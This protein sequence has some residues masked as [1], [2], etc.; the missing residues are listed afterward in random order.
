[1]KSSSITRKIILACLLCAFGILIGLIG[2]V[3]G[4]DLETKLDSIGI[5]KNILY[6]Y[7]LIFSILSIFCVILYER[8]NSELKPEHGSTP[9]FITRIISSLF[10]NPVTTYVWGFLTSNKTFSEL[11]LKLCLVFCVVTT[12]LTIIIATPVIIYRRIAINSYVSNA[13]NCLKRQDYRCFVS[14]H[15]MVITNYPEFNEDYE[16]LGDIYNYNLTEYS[17]AYKYYKLAFKKV[18]KDDYERVCSRGP[19]PCSPSSG[20]VCTETCNDIIK[21]SYQLE[22]ESIQKK[23]DSVF[24]ELYR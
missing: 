11:F 8:T 16:R 1:M 24:F 5:S 6:I 22:R 19:G 7:L 21:K 17:K 12:S 13:E 20:L 9:S 15:E 23:L 18:E 3:V 10:K 4:N 14:T 2:E